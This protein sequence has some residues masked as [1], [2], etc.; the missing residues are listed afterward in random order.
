MSETSERDDLEK[1]WR[2]VCRACSGI[3]EGDGCRGKGCMHRA[4]VDEIA[5]ALKETRE[6]LEAEVRALRGK[7][8]RLVAE[9]VRRVLDCDGVSSDHIRAIES[10][11]SGKGGE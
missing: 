10:V 6:P 5:A 2:I 7:R 9:I 4:E 3:P 8:K 1:A 11:L